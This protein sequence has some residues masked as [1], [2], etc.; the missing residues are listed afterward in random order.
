M[1]T[2]KEKDVTIYKLALICFSFLTF[3]TVIK[4]A[5]EDRSATN[6]KW[7]NLVVQ[8]G[9]ISVVITCC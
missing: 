5:G 7:L 3:L 2:H 6:G 8:N 9:D 1:K 4:V